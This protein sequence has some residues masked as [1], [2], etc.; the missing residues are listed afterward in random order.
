MQYH[1]AQLH[2]YEL[3]LSDLPEEMGRSTSVTA[4]LDNLFLCHQALTEILEAYFSIP[5]EEYLNL[6]FSVFGQFAHAFIVL[7]KLATL[8]VPGWDVNSLPGKLDFAATVEEAA[9]RFEQTARIW[10]DGEKSFLHS[11]ND[12]TS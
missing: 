7:A 2:A 6:P 3:C 1:T 11:S 4:R 5:A 10:T 9:T 8:E 12:T